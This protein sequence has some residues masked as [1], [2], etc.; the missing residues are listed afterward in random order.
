[1]W[2]AWLTN[3]VAD[4]DIRTISTVTKLAHL[5]LRKEVTISQALRF[6][7]VVELGQDVPKWEKFYR[8]FPGRAVIFPIMAFTCAPLFFSGSGFDLL[9][10]FFAGTLIALY[11]L[12]SRNISAFDGMQDSIIAAIAGIVAQIALHVS[13][14]TW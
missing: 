13:A 9:W 14:D 2:L 12:A 8:E 4:Y 10:T 1:M 6:M 7:D 3:E 5:V 11:V